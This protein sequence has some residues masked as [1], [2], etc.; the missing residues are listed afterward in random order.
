MNRREFLHT[1]LTASAAAG[2]CGCS[3]GAL[4]PGTPEPPA[5]SEFDGYKYVVGTQA[6]GA[7]YQFTQRPRLLEMAEVIR[8]MGSNTLKFRLGGG[9]R[10]GIRSDLYKSLR[11]IAAFEPVTRQIFEM[12]FAHYMMWAFTPLTNMQ[13]DRD[14]QIYELSCYLLQKYNRTRKTFYLGH[15]EGDWQIRGRAGSTM[16][17]TPKRI[18]EQIRWLNRRQNA[19]DQA[20][21][22][23]PHENVNVFCYT[24]VNLVRDSIL[25]R[26]TMTNAVLPHVSV[27]YVSYSAYD[28]SNKDDLEKGVPE[29]LDYIQSKL[30]PKKE[31]H[32]KRIWIGEYGYPAHRYAPDEQ[33]ARTRRLIKTALRWGCEFILYW[34]L[35]NNE[36]DSEGRQ[37]GFWLIDDKGLK[38]P[39]Y[40]THE[41][42]CEWGRRY[43]RDFYRAHRRLPSFEQYRNAALEYMGNT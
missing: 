43:V 10:D 11:E 34:E 40:H 9:E 30:P 36:L 16:D 33:N 29:A 5:L 26:P 35:Y 12:P 27:D 32:G 24:E 20:R 39:V 23:T 7:R 21:K 22:D 14:E 25:G 2:L 13:G 41:T 42:F 1:S 6:F 18:A 3:L 19:V 8:T 4:K 15:W 28:S 37:R 38:Q 31:I 17:A